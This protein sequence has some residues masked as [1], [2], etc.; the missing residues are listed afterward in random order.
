MKQKDIDAHLPLRPV[1]FM[2]LAV[3]R[4]GAAH[5][6]G[7]VQEVTSRTNGKVKLRAGNLYRVLDR[8]QERNLVQ[9]DERRRAKVGDDPRRTYYTVTRL[10]RAVLG[11]EAELM[12][13]LVSDVIGDAG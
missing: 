9:L 4:D 2:V 11:A 6:Y 5:G 1:E 10:G 8:M 3:L 7:I 12:A 13:G